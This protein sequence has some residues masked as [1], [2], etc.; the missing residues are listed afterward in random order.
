MKARASCG[1]LLSA[2]LV[3]SVHE[4]DTEVELVLPRAGL[5]RARLKVGL[6]DD[7]LDGPVREP[8]RHGAD[9]ARGVGV[10]F[11]IPTVSDAYL[12]SPIIRSCPSIDKARTLG[13]SPTV[14]VADGFRRTIQTYLS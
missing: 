13:W 3:G 12:K 5:I 11:D 14:G 8:D 6:E 9:V 7:L 4:A 1:E 10:R 2:P